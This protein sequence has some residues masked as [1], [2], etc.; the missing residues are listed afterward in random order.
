MR[1]HTG[2]IS[3]LIV[4]AGPAGLAMAGRLREAGCTF[5]IVEKTNRVADRW[6]QH[7]DR[8]HL[9]SVKQWS[10]LPHLPFPEDYPRYV[11]RKQ[12][13]EYLEHYSKTFDILP[14]FGVE[15][16]DM[17]RG[18][19]DVWD[20]ST[21]QGTLQARN[22]I[23]AT[24]VNRVPNRPS[25]EGMDAF[26]GSIS[27]S[28]SY[29]NPEPFKGSRVLVIGMGNTGAEIALDLANAGIPVWIS[30]RSPIH[31]V[32]RDLNGRPV[33]VTAKQLERL[34]LGLGNWLGAKV[35]RLYFGNLRKYG[36]QKPDR[37]PAVEIRET[38][39]T[40]VI[41]IG[42]VKAIKEGRVQVCRGVDHFTDEG[43]VFDDNQLLSCEHVILATGYHHQLSDF[44]KGIDAFLDK[45]GYPM[46]PIGTAEL[47]G[48]YFLGFDDYK[49][50]GILGSIYDDSEVILKHILKD[51]ITVRQ[52]PAS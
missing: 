51:K 25:W 13:V 41:D 45:N 50:G 8:L 32:P 3:N 1:Q 22:I 35:Q 38:G 46:S 11:P 5:T 12:F 28:V 18:I 43:V 52:D 14:E 29:K 33:Q 2:L 9:H 42:T 6:H 19:D 40:P 49:I 37:Y 34:P 17:T 30:V 10:H 39:R 16:L 15:V 36:L 26:A 27:H 7:Y 21:N 47:S 31:I 44:I 24:G 23:I 20:V 48:L 4:G